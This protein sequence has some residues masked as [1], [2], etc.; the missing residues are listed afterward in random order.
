MD[1]PD[2]SRLRRLV[3]RGFTPRMVSMLE[4]Q[5]RAWAVTIVDHALE[6]GVC[7]F[8]DEVAY[9]LPMHMIADIVGIPGGDRAE[10][11]GLVRKMLDM[12]DPQSGRTE[13]ELAESL[14]QTYAYAHELAEQKRR[15]P[16]D[17][18]WS[19]L[20][21][22]EVE[23]SDGAPTRLSE[24]ELDL[25]FILLVIAGSE[26]T[27]DSISAG[28]LALLENPA[29]MELMRRDASVLAPRL[30]RLFAGRRRPPI[31]VEPQRGTSS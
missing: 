4:D 14:G 31:S 8:V 19:K 10:L 9:Q 5:A 20:T 13:V 29:Q 26:T 12:L 24:L 1:P 11:F 27:R 25:F 3:N 28:L 22:A 21:V 30:T 15:S 17:D 23:H 6:K 7:N 18:V 16:R 2:H